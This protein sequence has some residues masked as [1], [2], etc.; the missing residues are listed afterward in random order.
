VGG[1]YDNFVESDLEAFSALH[2]H[3]RLDDKHRIMIGPWA[4]NMSTPFLGVNYGDDSSSPIRSYQIEWFDHWL[5]GAPEEARPFS[6]EAW[7]AVRAEVDEAPVHIFVMGVNRWRDEPDWPLARARNTSLYLASDGAS[8]ALSGDGVLQSKPGRGN[9]M[10]DQFTYDPRNPVPTRGGAVCCDPKIFAWGPMDQRPVENRQ[11]VLVYTSAPLKQ[12]LE[13]TGPIRVVLYASTSA[14]DTDFT[15]KLVDVF[16]NGEARNLT[17]GILRIRYRHGLDK[18][19]LAEPGEV[20]PLSIDAGVTSNV[21]LAGHSIRVEISSSN[22]P[23][24]DRNPNTGRAFADETTLKKAQQVI[25]HSRQYPSHIVL[26]VIPSSEAGP[27]KV[28]RRQNTELTSA[29]A[30]RY[31]AKRSPVVEAKPLPIPAR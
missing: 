15:A 31:G 19:E 8:N 1:W 2:K 5:K 28:A 6:P 23:R 16:P 3:G 22:F 4:H 14:A 10:S 20:Y 29:S 13:V 30:A 26:P 18:P 9:T 11:D 27:E 17:D 7:H 12:D 25:Y 24:F 21:F